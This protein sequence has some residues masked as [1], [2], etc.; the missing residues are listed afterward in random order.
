M[1]V[2]RRKQYFESAFVS[3]AAVY[4]FLHTLQRDVTVYEYVVGSFVI[5]KKQEFLFSR[6]L[7][8]FCVLSTFLL[9]LP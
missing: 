4:R 2:G 6:S 1:W 5:D 9:C 7:L 3:C 8:S